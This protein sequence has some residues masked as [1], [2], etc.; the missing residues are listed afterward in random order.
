MS[1]RGQ[2]S[3]ERFD[4]VAVEHG[5]TIS[6]DDY[7]QDVVYTKGRRRVSVRFTAGAGAAPR[8]Y[9]AAW[10]NSCRARGWSCREYSGP[11]VDWIIERLE[12]L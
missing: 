10:N 9:A 4:A 7:G 3:R 11:L 2:S 6:P 5:W 12:T 8:P 1:K